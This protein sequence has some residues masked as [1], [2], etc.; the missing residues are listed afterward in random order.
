VRWVAA[1]TAR[2]RH[3]HARLPDDLSLAVLAPVQAQCTVRWVP[4]QTH[5][6]SGVPAPSCTLDLDVLEQQLQDDRA[7]GLRPRLLALGA[8]ANAT[9]VCVCPVALPPFARC[10]EV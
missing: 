8:A 4:L 3:V 1:R 6:D 10:D 5:G 2:R 9:G 7:Q